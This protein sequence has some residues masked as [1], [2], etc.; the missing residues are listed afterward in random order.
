MELFEAMAKRRSTRAYT[1]EGVSAAEVEKVVWAADAAPVGG[2][3]YEKL[4]L[5]VVTDGV[6]L[7]KMRATAMGGGKGGADPFYGAPAVVLVSAK[8]GGGGITPLDAANAACL[9][10][11]MHLAATGLGLGSVYIWGAIG[12]MN[13]DA[14]LLKGLGIPEGFLLVSALAFGHAADGEFPARAFQGMYGRN[15]VR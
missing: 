15:D 3:H 6:V 9:V 5:T 14:G 10:E 2:G 13:E 1:G 12:R 4:H 8:A 11:N 7:G